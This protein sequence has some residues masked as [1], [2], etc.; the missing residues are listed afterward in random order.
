M[1]Q[2]TIRY[3]IPYLNLPGLK[4]TQPSN[5]NGVHLTY[6]GIPLYLKFSNLMRPANDLVPRKTMLKVMWEGLPG[7]DTFSFVLKNPEEHFVMVQTHSDLYV[8]EAIKVFQQTALQH[9]QT[10][11]LDMLAKMAKDKSLKNALDMTCEYRGKNTLLLIRSK[12]LDVS[13]VLGLSWETRSFL[14]R[15][16]L[17]DGKRL[18]FDSEE[19]APSFLYDFV[20]G[21]SKCLG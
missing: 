5:K 16:K 4:V 6:F 21:F 9:L 7:N 11:F 14:G 3:Y 13:G 8:D 19:S 12:A 20:S 1:E 10:S 17:P 18:T 15:L 2:S